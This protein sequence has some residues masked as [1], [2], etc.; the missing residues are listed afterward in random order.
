MASTY[1]I[2]KDF[3]NCHKLLLIT[4]KN[5]ILVEVI[6]GRHLVLGD[7]MHETIPLD[8]ILKGHHS[9]IAFNVI[10]S[11]SNLVVLGLS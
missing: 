1:F 10:K 8:V 6:D 2:N 9:T 11:P 4:K 3:V 7:V 5:P